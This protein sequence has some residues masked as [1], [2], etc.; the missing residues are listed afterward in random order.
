MLKIDEM[1][2]LKVIGLEAKQ[3]VTK[4]DYQ[5]LGPI[6]ERKTRKYSKIRMLIDVGDLNGILLAAFWEDLKMSVNHP[7]DFERVA[8]ISS[9]N[10]EDLMNK[11]IAPLIHSEVK[12]FDKSQKARQW[13]LDS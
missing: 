8:I 6:I 10:I 2:N 12:I 1:K 7:S 5:K 9:N 13:I 3:V 11:P 4:E